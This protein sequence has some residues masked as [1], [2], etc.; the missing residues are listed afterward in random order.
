M[1][2]IGNMTK[3]AMMVTTIYNFC[4]FVQQNVEEQLR[5]RT[6]IQNLFYIYQLYKLNSNVKIQESIHSPNLCE[7]NGTQTVDQKNTIV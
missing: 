3:A 5:Y 7:H 6:I 2:M 1:R 4:I